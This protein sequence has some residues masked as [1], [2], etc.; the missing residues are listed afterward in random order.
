MDTKDIDKTLNN[1]IKFL[2]L[3]DKLKEVERKTKPIGSNRRER[4]AE[5]CWQA[6]LAA[7]ILK[8]H[9][10]TPIDLFKAMLML[11]IHDLTEVENGDVFHYH[12]EK[13][14]DLHEKEKA[15]LKKITE[16]LEPEQQKEIESL[17][18]EFEANETPEANFAN[19]IDRFLPQML[20]INNEG[21]TWKE[22]GLGIELVRE[23]NGGIEKGSVGLWEIARTMWKQWFKE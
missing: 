22:F 18:L 21:G 16:V 20:N 3:A 6:M 8:D 23:K 7:Y 1:K 11:L 17:W 14:A 9:S 4:S 2:V 19:A 5:H 12:K 15:A 10:N 13:V